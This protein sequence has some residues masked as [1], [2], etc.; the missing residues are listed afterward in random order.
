MRARF[1]P[2]SVQ[3]SRHVKSGDYLNVFD[4]REITNK[5]DSLFLRYDYHASS[6]HGRIIYSN[7]KVGKREDLL[8]LCLEQF[9]CKDI[10]QA[11][12]KNEEDQAT[13]LIGAYFLHQNTLYLVK[14]VNE[15][16]QQV[17]AVPAP[18]NNYNTIAL[19]IILEITTCL[20]TNIINISIHT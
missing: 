11:N 4:V 1:P 5:K 18:D 15:A 19:D 16:S 13:D 10:E 17:H 14:S 2:I 8:A 3:T 20:V 7:F 12:R 6:L 9:F